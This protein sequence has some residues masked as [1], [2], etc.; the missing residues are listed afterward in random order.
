MA[1]IAIS[2][3]EEYNSLR[4]LEAYFHYLS[5]SLECKECNDE[6]NKRIR[7]KKNRIQIQGRNGREKK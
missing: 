1:L 3:R 4:V 7:N 5:Y 2:I 6:I